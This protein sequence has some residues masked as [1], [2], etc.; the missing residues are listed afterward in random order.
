MN[1]T[2][3]DLSNARW[4]AWFTVALG[5]ATAGLLIAKHIKQRDA[6][7]TTSALWWLIAIYVL[8]GISFI[9]HLLF[10]VWNEAA[11]GLGNIFACLAFIIWGVAFGVRKDIFNIEGLDLFIWI[12][13]IAFAVFNIIQGLF[14]INF[15]SKGVSY[16]KTRVG[17][18]K[19]GGQG[20]YYDNWTRGKAVLSTRDSR[21]SVTGIND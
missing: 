3:A 9:F 18:M 5:L 16:D 8:L 17:S 7:G 12:L 13:F 14:W 15:W 21:K 20:S 10:H 19:I 1:T 11:Y 6:I 2:K 4:L